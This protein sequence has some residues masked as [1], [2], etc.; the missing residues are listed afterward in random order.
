MTHGAT[1][2]RIDVCKDIPNEKSSQMGEGKLIPRYV[3]PFEI[4]ERVRGRAYRLALS[5]RVSESTRCVP[6]LDAEEMCI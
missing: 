1:R 2:R 3:G 5:T 4:L 6:C